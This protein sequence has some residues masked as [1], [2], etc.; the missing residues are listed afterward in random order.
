MLAFTN[1]PSIDYLELEVPK[2]FLSLINFKK[3]WIFMGPVSFPNFQRVLHLTRPRSHSRVKGGGESQLGTAK[4][5]LDKEQA[6]CL[7]GS[8]HV[9]LL[10]SGLT[11]SKEESVCWW[12]ADLWCPRTRGPP[13][14]CL[15]WMEL[16]GW[17]WKLTDP[18]LDLREDSVA[19]LFFPLTP[20]SPST[21]NIWSEVVA[22]LKFYA[23]L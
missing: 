11:F 10:L 12:W 8:C 15:L 5:N 19:M 14:P 3:D 7:C 23:W 18:S 13:M 1:K 2:K 17:M 16:S 9:W 6:A 21:W 4:G 22:Y 20:F